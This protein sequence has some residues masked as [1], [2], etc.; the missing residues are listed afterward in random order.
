MRGLKKQGKYSV[1]RKLSHPGGKKAQFYRTK[2]KSLEKKEEK[3]RGGK[4]FVRASV[5]LESSRRRAKR[6]LPKRKIF[7]KTRGRWEQTRDG[8]LASSGA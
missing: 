2:K 8:N 5:E 1:G 7:T 3:G 6:L 4:G